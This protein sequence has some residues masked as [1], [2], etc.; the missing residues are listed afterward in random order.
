VQFRFGY[1]RFRFPKPQNEIPTVF[2][3]KQLLTA[4]VTALPRSA[5]KQIRDRYWQIKSRVLY[6][7]LYK[8]LGLEC[9]LRSGITLRVA[10]KGEW[11][12]YNDIF[13]NGEYDV[14]ILQ[15]LEKRPPLRPL[16]VLDLGANL[17]FF[18][19]RVVDLI[20]QKHPE[21]RVDV[22]MVE[23]S[24]RVFDELG[25]R[26]KSQN[27]HEAGFRMVQGLVGRR[28]GGAPLHESALHVKNTIMSDENRD[29]Q[30]IQFIDIGVL[31]EHVEE[32]DLLKCDIE[33]AELLFLESYENLLSKVKNAVFELHHEMCDTKKCRDILLGCGFR[34]IVLRKTPQFCVSFL[35][36]D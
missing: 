17:G 14:P 11:W 16:T 25:K 10:S 23:A 22:T 18:T 9:T 19:L 12:I 35:T 24:P 6:Q 20:R 26:M 33:G 1:N 2:V 32:I 29:G 5:Q 3:I 7:S 21:C 8:L 13:V 4:V 31:M 34:E 27:L 36:R 30:N 28:T 15:V